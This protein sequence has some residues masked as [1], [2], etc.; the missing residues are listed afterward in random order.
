MHKFRHNSENIYLTCFFIISTC[1]SYPVFFL[2]QKIT[3]V[4]YSEFLFFTGTLS[5]INDYD[6]F[7]KRVVHQR[8]LSEHNDVKNDFQTSLIMSKFRD[9][10]K[11]Y[12]LLNLLLYHFNTSQSIFY[13]SFSTRRLSQLCFL[14]VFSYGHIIFNK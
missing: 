5:L 1:L 3:S 9:R 14:R 12:F 11:K 2:T 4:L 8:Y 6:T 13:A 10:R 7:L